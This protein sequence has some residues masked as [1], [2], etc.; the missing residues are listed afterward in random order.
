MRSVLISIAF[1]FAFGLATPRTVAGP[2]LS[3]VA[4]VSTSTSLDFQDPASEIILD[5]NASRVR[6]WYQNPVWI[7]IGALALVVLL[8]IVVLMTQVGIGPTTVR[9]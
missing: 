8:V 6:A 4:T 3:P 1:L 9:G 7:A 2:A 5:L